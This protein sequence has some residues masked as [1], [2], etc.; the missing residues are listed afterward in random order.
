[1]A[2]DV[3]IGDG[4]VPITI[5]GQE[6]VLKPSYKAALALSRSEGLVLLSSR[7]QSLDVDAMTKVVA[8][9][10]GRNP[11]DLGERIYKSGLTNVREACV[12]FIAALANGGRLPR[13]VQ[14]AKESPLAIAEEKTGT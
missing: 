2:D 11:S 3:K 9:G 8:E 10:L 6:L 12:L 13:A 5:D 4:D 14:E 1:M 7:C